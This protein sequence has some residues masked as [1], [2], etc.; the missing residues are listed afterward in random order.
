MALRF[1]RSSRLLPATLWLA[2]CGGS[3]AAPS[4][5]PPPAASAAAV[6]PA[7][8]PPVGSSYGYPD[9][10]VAEVVDR[11]HG[12]EIADPYRWL[13][14]KSKPGVSEWLT[15]QD[16]FARAHLAKL[17]ERDAIAE[18]LRAL[19]YVEGH[20]TPIRRG[21]RWFYAKR[22]KD[23]EKW[24]VYV[25]EGSLTDGK[26]RA[27]LDPNAWS[28]DGSVALGTWSPSRDG[29]KLAYNVKVNNS[30][31]ATLHVMDVASGEISKVDR[32]EGAKYAQPSWMPD[33]AGFFYTWLPTDPA[34]SAT[35]RPGFAEVRYHRLGTSPDNDPTVVPRSGDAKTFVSAGVS[36]DGRWLV[37]E[38]AHGWTSTDVWFRDLKAAPVVLPKG[39]RVAAAERAK[40]APFD[41]GASFRP[42]A[43]GTPYK[44]EVT[45]WAGRLYVETDDG[46][47]NNHVMV[48][49]PAK[50]ERAAWRVLVPENPKATLEGSGIVG[51]RLAL[52]YLEDVRSRLEV[53]TLDGK[54]DHE[55]AL[56]APGSA[57]GLVGRP[58]DDRAF[59]SFTSL[60]HPQEI[61][62]TSVKTGKTS[63]FFRVDLPFD[64]AP[65]EV[66]PGFA[67]SKDGTR[68]PYFVVQKKGTPRDGSAPALVYGYGGFVATI[69]PTFTSSVVPWLERGGVYVLTNLRGGAE[70]GEAWHRAG[71][72]DKKQNVFDDLY[73]ILEKLAADKVTRADRIALRGGSNGGLLV[74]A[75]YTQRPELF[76]VALC[77]VPLL[78]MVRYHLFGSGRTWIEEY[79]SAEDAHDFGVLRA[80]SPYHHVEKGKLYPSMLLLSAD[81]DDRV[82]PLH[83]W[84]FAALAQARSAGG[85]VLLRIEKNSGHGGADLVRAAVEKSADELAFAL[86]EI[87]KGPVTSPAAH[88]S[89]R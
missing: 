81:S 79:G 32:I 46:A 88:A 29:K 86:D 62:E 19:S 10:K 4:A 25:R 5:S 20:A 39:P 47:P 56:P 48:V 68:V 1:A 58:D 23:S 51:G 28:K 15:A 60:V 14:D 50:P 85:P 6:A 76:R 22:A 40:G 65:F 74:G 31:E 82:A 55:V 26:E 12:T 83:A 77:G 52:S 8:P 67:S 38:L 72:R 89:L 43:V 45:P 41:P 70:Y 87:K 63:R 59:F 37:A 73:A 9:T 24:V 80:Y 21:T 30:D 42:L 34:I 78:D 36:W 49:D 35:E 53:R 69:K 75:A 16:R 7:P 54:L 84:K 57:S 33:S 44:Y 11:L 66:I 18:R 71:M 3:Q 2:A 64:P 61:H 17:P 27:L 13:E